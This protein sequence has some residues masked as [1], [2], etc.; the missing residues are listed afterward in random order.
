[1]GRRLGPLLEM[2]FTEMLLVDV[3]MEG[4]SA[5][6]RDR[7]AINTGTSGLSLCLLTC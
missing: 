2:L 3:R 4:V 1:M 6:S 5:G 7:T